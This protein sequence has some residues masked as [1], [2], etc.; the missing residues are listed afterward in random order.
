MREMKCISWRGGGGGGD[1]ERAKN[2]GKIGKGRYAEKE[3][4]GA[5]ELER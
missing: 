2:F 4:V 1:C 5:S 3:R